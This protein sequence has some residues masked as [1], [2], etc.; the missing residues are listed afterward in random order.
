M[1]MCVRVCFVVVSVLWVGFGVRMCECKLGCWW[2]L[3]R[4]Y[5]ICVCVGGGGLSIYL[6]YI[7][8]YLL[9]IY[10]CV[11]VCVIS[12]ECVCAVCVFVCTHVF[13]W[14]Y[15]VLSPAPG[16]SGLGVYR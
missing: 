6:F 7:C 13:R 8:M 2:R 14:V 4:K 12:G 9:H 15:F 10:I 16:G 1:Y 3:P 11:C 5:I